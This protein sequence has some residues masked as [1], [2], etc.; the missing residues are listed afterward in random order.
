MRILLSPDGTQN[1][2]MDFAKNLL[3]YFVAKGKRIYGDSFTVYNIH[4]LLHLA[5]DCQNLHSSLNDISAF[6]FENYLQVIKK[7][8]RN[9]NN[10]VA[11]IAKRKREVETHCAQMYK[12]ENE[13]KCSVRFRDS[14]FC[15]NNKLVFVKK[16]LDDTRYEC[17][18]VHFSKVQY[19]YEKPLKSRDLSIGLIPARHCSLIS[20]KILSVEELYR[21]LVI[22][23]CKDSYIVLP[24]IHCY[25]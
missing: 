3:S 18:V 2:Y 7:S 15:H 10:P 22:L 19:F 1:E 14:C 21:K 24:M 23:P 4:N 20:K 8:I 12:K 6:K 17:E 16:R 13:I 11:Q 5:H 25:I 9:A